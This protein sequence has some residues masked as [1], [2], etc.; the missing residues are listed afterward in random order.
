MVI[1]VAVLV[2][3]GLSLWLRFSRIGLYVRA[4]SVDPVTTG[5]QGVDTDRVS[6]VVVAIGA[7]L[8]GLSGTIAAP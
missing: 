4:S 2:A 6:A 3:A 7:G 8:A 5:M 1:G